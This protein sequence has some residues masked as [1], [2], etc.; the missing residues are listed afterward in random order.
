MWSSHA[1]TVLDWVCAHVSQSIVIQLTKKLLRVSFSKIFR[2]AQIKD[3]MWR[4]LPLHWWNLIL[5]NKKNSYNTVVN[6]I[7]IKMHRNV[8][9][10]GSPKMIIFFCR[11]LETKQQE[12]RRPHFFLIPGQSVQWESGEFLCPLCQNPSNSV[13]PLLTAPPL[14]TPTERPTR[15]LGIKEW[16]EVTNMALEL[17]EGDVIDTGNYIS[18]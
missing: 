11:F 18:V 12:H 5:I 2:R 14:T 16:R 1:R 13:L 15:E 3:I 7:T 10:Y 4:K 6:A 17:A 9:V 8:L